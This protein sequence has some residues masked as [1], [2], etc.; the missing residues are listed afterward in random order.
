M[1]YQ[2]LRKAA[3]QLQDQ[4]MTAYKQLKDELIDNPTAESIACAKAYYA[5]LTKF[6]QGAGICDEFLDEEG[7][8]FTSAQKTLLKHF[9]TLSAVVSSLGVLAI[10]NKEHIEE[11]VDAPDWL[12]PQHMRS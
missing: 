10:E 7:V 3:Q 11:L 12:K 9:A 8:G 1:D 2:K 4:L 6:S 5:A